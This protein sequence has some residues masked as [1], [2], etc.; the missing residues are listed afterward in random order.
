MP[1]TDEMVVISNVLM[2]FG[3][4]CIAKGYMLEIAHS[5]GR[6]VGRKGWV[7]LG[8]MF[9]LAG[10][11]VLLSRFKKNNINKANTLIAINATAGFVTLCLMLM[12]IFHRPDDPDLTIGTGIAS[13]GVVIASNLSYYTG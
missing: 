10:L 3:L 7:I 5:A 9:V 4:L 6:L 2:F 13:I 11:G 1:K 8:T 12:S